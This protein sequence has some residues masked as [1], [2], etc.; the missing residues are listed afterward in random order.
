MHSVFGKINSGG[1]KHNS[2]YVGLVL[3]SGGW[4]SLIK[5]V[6]KLPLF[7]Y[8]WSEHC[9]LSFCH[10]VSIFMCILINVKI[11]EISCR[12][13]N[14]SFLII[15]TMKKSSQMS[16]IITQRKMPAKCQNPHKMWKC[17]QNAHKMQWTET[18]EGLVLFWIITVY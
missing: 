8:S 1:L 15:I 2:L 6:F 3:P 17:L 13:A 18:R 16:Y 12:H 7:P 9:I 10:S 5:S 14:I 11:S 4:Q